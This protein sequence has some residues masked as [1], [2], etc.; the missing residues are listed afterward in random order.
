MTRMRLTSDKK[1]KKPPADLA[2]LSGSTD[3]LRCLVYAYQ[4]LNLEHDC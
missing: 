1:L 4:D 2:Q 3:S